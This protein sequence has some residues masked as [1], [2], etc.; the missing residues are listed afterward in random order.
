MQLTK[1][2]FL[3]N[4]IVLLLLVVS[5]GVLLIIIS[6]QNAIVYVYC[7]AMALIVKI[8]SIKLPSFFHFILPSLM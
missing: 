8:E 3:L 5:L 7:E 2:I 1:A 6:V 4:S